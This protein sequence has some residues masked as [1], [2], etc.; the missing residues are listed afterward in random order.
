MV[1]QYYKRNTSKHNGF[2]SLSNICVLYGDPN[3]TS[4]SVRNE[5]LISILKE[6]NSITPYLYDHLLVI[7]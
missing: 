6:V 1:L 3:L 4:I 2:R 5:N 7:H